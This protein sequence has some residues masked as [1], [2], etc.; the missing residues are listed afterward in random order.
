MSY[1]NE[2]EQEIQT[3][4]VH[5][6]YELALS[7]IEDELKMPYVPMKLEEK[8]LSWQAECQQAL[9]IPQ[10]GSLDF[11]LIKQFL[12][13]DDAQLHQAALSQLANVNLRNALED[14]KDILDNQTDPLVISMILLHLIDQEIDAT[15]QFTKNGLKYEINPRQIEHPVNSDGYKEAYQLLNELTFKEP[16]LTNLC[17]QLLVHEV[18]MALPLI[19]EQ[20]ESN[21]LALAIYKQGLFLLNRESEWYNYKVEN[22]LE[23]NEGLTLFSTL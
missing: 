16:S 14:L 22:K 21:L 19:Y 12:M 8:L 3:L 11:E 17:H 15:F 5:H 2:L 4:M 7:K 1:Y 6:H 20:E 9:N 23:E 10:K 13:D 18:I